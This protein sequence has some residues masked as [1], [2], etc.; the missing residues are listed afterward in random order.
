MIVVSV[1]L[2]AAVVL[3]VQSGVMKLFSSKLIGLVVSEVPP[4]VVKER[5]KVPVIGAAYCAPAN[6][7]AMP[8]DWLKVSCCTSL[9]P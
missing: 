5:V 2:T 8:S 1:A 7:V 6:S 3:A 9:P 4:V